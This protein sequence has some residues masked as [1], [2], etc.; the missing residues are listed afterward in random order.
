MYLFRRNFALVILLI[1]AVW[2]RAGEH[3]FIFDLEVIGVEDGLPQSTVRAITQDED[4]F[5]YFATDDGVSRFDGISHQ[6]ISMDSVSQRRLF[7]FSQVCTRN[8][9][10]WASSYDGGI[11]V[12]DKHSEIK[13]EVY[14]RDFLPE[15]ETN[16]IL[17]CAIDAKGTLWFALTSG[18]FN[19]SLSNELALQ[20]VYWLKNSSTPEARLNHLL[21]NHQKQLFVA[22][23]KG[24]KTLYGGQFYDLPVSQPFKQDIKRLFFDSQQRL[25][26]ISD[27]KVHVLEIQDKQWQLIS[28][29]LLNELNEQIKNER[30]TSLSQINSSQFWV[31]TQT[32]GVWV[33]DELTN[34]LIHLNK[35]SQTHKITDNNIASILQ[36]HDGSV[37]LGTWL[38]G[39]NKLRFSFPGIAVMSEFK[40]KD[41]NLFEPSVRSIFRASDGTYW[42]GTDEEGIFTTQNFSESFEHYLQSKENDVGLT[43]NSIRVIYERHNNELWVGT[44]NG[45]VIFDPLN[46]DKPFNSISNSEATTG[47]RIRSILEDH[48]YQ[49][50]VGSYDQ[51]LSYWN[52]ETKAFE[53]IDLI[54]HIDP[55]LVTTL[56]LDNQNK[57]WVGTDNFGVFVL[58]PKSKRLIN[59]YK[60]GENARLGTPNNFIWSIFQEDEETYWFGSYGKGLGRYN[61]TS[62]IFTHITSDQGLPNNVVY[63]ILKD[64]HG[65]FWSSTNKGLA[66]FNNKLNKFTQYTRIHGLPHNEFNSGSYFQEDNGRLFFGGLAGLVAIEP[67]KFLNQ[68]QSNRVF[69][70][71]L[72]L[73]DESAFGSKFNQIEGVPFAPIRITAKKSYEKIKMVFSSS[74]FFSAGEQTF[75]YRLI[76]MDSDWNYSQ[77]DRLVAF[78]NQLSPGKYRMEVTQK[79]ASGIWSESPLSFELVLLPPWW[80][81]SWAYM[82]YTLLLMSGIALIYW[83]WIY[84]QKRNHQIMLRLNQLVEQRT[85]LLKAKNKELREVNQKLL[86]ANQRL[87]E[88]SMTDALTGMGNRRM[89][90]HYLERDLGDIK[91][92]H[93]SLNDDYSNLS[94]VQERDILFFMIDIDFFKEVNDQYG[95]AVGD[96]VL[97]QVSNVI[98][99]VIREGDYVIRYGGEEFLLVLRNS[100]RT[101]ANIVADRLLKAFAEYSF[102][103]DDSHTISLT[104]SIGF[105]PLPF[106][107]FCFEQFTPEQVI[108]IA[109]H[110]LYCAKASGR[111]CWVGMYGSYKNSS[112]S[113]KEIHDDPMSLYTRSQ[114]QLL[115]SI[116][117]EKLVW[118]TSIDY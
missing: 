49:L 32:N 18:V 71:Q 66:R 34:R 98:G 8:G 87:E 50:W 39:V 46:S 24:I 101:Q 109:D 63:S 105:V 111:N 93:A 118:T 85:Q 114:I 26:A 47:R 9:T 97:L 60:E 107:N 19:V 59:H 41:G 99:H 45:V 52:D 1:V 31:A 69:L 65:W 29:P 90:F 44:E 81:S 3:S 89:L 83:Y 80:A 38:S 30:T 35:R 91:R 115:A 113:L 40:T 70:N 25:W 102:E 42:V 64:K 22:T 112:V 16:P 92:A 37:W 62:K 51:G 48:L 54:E 53:K 21:V 77:G 4:G 56:V 73:N 15:Q 6:R 36:S 33:L 79:S 67:H 76:G 61:V 11:L 94:S 2:T 86:D 103:I 110:C 23:S 78:Y 12:F 75:A 20:E 43:S 106:S 88:V 28:F 100:P 13:K 14:L 57:L 5:I 27:N 108:Q 96:R 58:D 7:S 74:D 82:V 55:P 68:S 104:C 84:T 17:G 95:H 117:Y 116:D 10:V 72:F